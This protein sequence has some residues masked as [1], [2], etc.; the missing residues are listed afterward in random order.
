MRPSLSYNTPMV[1]IAALQQEICCLFQRIQERV[2]ERRT[3]RGQERRGGMETAEGR[4]KRVGG[5]RGQREEGTR[6]EKVD[7]RGYEGGEGSK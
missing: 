3:W 5:R 1:D 4:E 6:A 2:Q 7:G